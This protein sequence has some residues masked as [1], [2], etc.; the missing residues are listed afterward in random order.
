MA[1]DVRFFRNR[2]RFVGASGSPAWE[3]A[4]VIFHGGL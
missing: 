3:T 1:D 2:V 4:L